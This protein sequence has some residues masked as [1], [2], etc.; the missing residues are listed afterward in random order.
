MDTVLGLLYTLFLVGF[1]FFLGYAKWGWQVYILKENL[2]VYK[3]MCKYKDQQ[4]NEYFQ[5]FVV[6]PLQEE[7][8]EAEVL[9]LRPFVIAEDG[10]RVSVDIETSVGPM[11]RSGIWPGDKK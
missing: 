5:E 10:T 9:D 4:I 2:H 11:A 3:E 6:K 7:H 1:G 8:E